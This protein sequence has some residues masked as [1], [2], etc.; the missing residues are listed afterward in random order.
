[1]AEISKL[2]NLKRLNLSDTNIT[3][4]SPEGVARLALEELGLAGMQI[5]DEGLRHL[6]GL[7]KLTM[8]NLTRTGVSDEGLGALAKMVAL[9]ELHLSEAKITDDGLK[10]LM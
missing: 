9:R 5:S 6:A 10:A 7:Q 3:D 1:M 4:Q 8:L 2:E